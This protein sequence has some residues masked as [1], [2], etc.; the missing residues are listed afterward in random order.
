MRRLLP[1]TALIL[2]T[3]GAG[4]A[5]AQQDEMNDMNTFPRPI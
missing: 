1:A 2:V 3:L 4:P 5:A